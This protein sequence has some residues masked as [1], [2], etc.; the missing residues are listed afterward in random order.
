MQGEQEIY[1][2]VDEERLLLRS[3]AIKPERLNLKGVLKTFFGVIGV[4]AFSMGA[5][6]YIIRS[7]FGGQSSV[8]LIKLLPNAQ[9][10]V[11]CQADA[12]CFQTCWE[13]C[14]GSHLPVLGG[15]DVVAYHAIDPGE[16]PVS[17]NQWHEALYG[18]Y[19]FWFVSE[20][21]KALFQV[22]EGTG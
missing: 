11:R 22:R 13:D 7:Y 3:K 6:K 19:R 10:D 21:N 17:G 5:G 1:V 16:P 15:I 9:Q 14:A 2:G 4:F 8:N 12:S 18:G 20:A